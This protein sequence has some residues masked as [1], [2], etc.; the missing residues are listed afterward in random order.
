[1]AAADEGGR[2]ARVTVSLVPSLQEA[3][4]TS[5]STPAT[6]LPTVP[7]GSRRGGGTGGE[8]A[9]VRAEVA[10][11][12]F[13]TSPRS[14]RMVEVS[15]SQELLE[16]VANDRTC[17]FSFP[18]SPP[19]S[20]SAH[21]EGDGVRSVSRENG[22]KE[23][24][25]TTPLGVSAGVKRAW[26][27]GGGAVGGRTSCLGDVSSASAVGGDAASS[28]RRGTPALP[29]APFPSPL[30]IRT[31]GPPPLF[32]V[33]ASCGTASGGA[34]VPG[35]W[36]WGEWGGGSS[37][38]SPFRPL[39]WCPLVTEHKEKKEGVGIRVAGSP[40][41][42]L[43]EGPPSFAWKREEEEEKT[44]PTPSSSSS[45]PPSPPPAWEEMDKGEMEASQWVAVAAST[46][47]FSWEV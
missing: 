25:T 47:S 45:S 26:R 33:S 36:S 1:M 38:S 35:P 28:T 44:P 27:S 21:G 39:V 10:S 31:G 29:T 8:E 23:E 19:S 17:R 42:G 32:R 4:W 2:S 41:F 16:T 6:R 12:G 22:V 15:D 9:L 14:P 34:D 20:L 3:S 40:F 24:E 46:A 13:P 5:F 43:V 18:V 37:F 11:L 7:S 30:V